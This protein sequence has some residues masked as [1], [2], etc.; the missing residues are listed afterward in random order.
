MLGQGLTYG[1]ILRQLGDTA[2][3]LNKSSLSRWKRGPYQ[4]W[5]KH[6]ERLEE[7]GSQLKFALSAVRQN[8]NHQIHEATQQIAALRISELFSQLDLSTLKMAVLDDPATLARLA[9][10]LPKLSQGGLE[11]ERQ[12]RELSS[13]QPA[14]PAQKTKGP[15]QR[16]LSRKALRYLEHKLHLM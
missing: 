16:G 5:L 10:L 8:Q 6:Q 3:S 2:R 7:S 12:R 9:S 14:A 4:T 1:E 11:C 13:S 15:I